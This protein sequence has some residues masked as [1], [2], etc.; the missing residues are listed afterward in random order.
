M[1]ARWGLASTLAEGLCFPRTLGA[2]LDRVPR[3]VERHEREHPSETL[4]A[5]LV[6]LSLLLCSSGATLVDRTLARLQ[7]SRGMRTTVRDAIQALHDIP[8]ALALAPRGRPSTIFRACHGRTTEALLCV[9]A[10]CRSPAVQS[11]IKRYV[12]HLRDVRSDIGGR[13][14]LREGIPAGPALAR[15][16]EAALLAKLDGTPGG[17]RAQLRVA[18]SAARRS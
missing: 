16:L 14:L 1:L 15:G 8:R 6:V 7:P 2:A 3:L 18:L 12:D 9:R 4:S 17:R 11:A 13:D 5:W 10:Q